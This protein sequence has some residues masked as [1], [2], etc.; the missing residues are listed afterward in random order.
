MLGRPASGLDTDAK[1]VY[2]GDGE[3]VPYDML[4]IATG[5]NARR[6]PGGAGTIA[7]V[8]ALR[9]LDDARA[10]K[11]ALDLGARTVVVG[12]GFI[13]SEVASSAK[14]DRKSVG[15]ERACQYV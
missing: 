10:I 15:R 12:A 9:T 2:V 5:A 7:G 1:A 13:G 14:Q 6:L 8:H 11:S 4:V 3:A